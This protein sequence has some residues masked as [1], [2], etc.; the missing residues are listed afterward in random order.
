M[1]FECTLFEGYGTFQ[2]HFWHDFRSQQHRRKPRFPYP[3]HE[4]TGCVWNFPESGFMRDKYPLTENKAGVGRLN[5]LSSLLPFSEA[6]VHT[7][8]RRKVTVEPQQKFLYS[9]HGLLERVLLYSARKVCNLH[10]GV[11]VDCFNKR[12]EQAGAVLRH[13]PREQQIALVGCGSQC[14]GSGRN[15]GRN[16]MLLVRVLCHGWTNEWEGACAPTEPGC[17]VANG[18]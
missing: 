17:R 4:I 1:Q 14:R 15:G 11:G 8:F 3:C 6:A 7:S 10:Y 13:S 18:I 16:G 12:Q 9:V 2:A 5:W